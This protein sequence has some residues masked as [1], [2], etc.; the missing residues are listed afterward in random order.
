MRYN[1]TVLGMSDIYFTVITSLFDGTFALAFSLLPTLVLFTRITPSLI[2]AS[3]FALLTGSFN[4]A[5]EVASPFVG[6]MVCKIFGVTSEN[7]DN[8]PTL[9]CIQ[10]FTTL[11]C[12]FFI[13]L[14]P[15]NAELDKIA[16][17]EKE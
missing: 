3:M 8:Y 4:F 10:V 5:N 6:S 7:L 12:L 16:Q 1:I 11:L 2:E 14:L 9:L 17:E 15:T 13:Q